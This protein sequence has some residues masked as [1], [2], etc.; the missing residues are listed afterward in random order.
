MADDQAA[1]REAAAWYAELFKDRYYLEVQ[2]HDS[3]GQATLNAR[4]FALAEGARTPGRRHQR[5]ALPQA[6][7]PRRARR[8]ALHRARQGSQ[9]RRPDALRSRALLQERAGDRRAASRIGRTCSR[10]RSD[11]RRESTSSSGRSTTCR[12]SRCRPASRREN[13]L[14]TTLATGGRE[15]A[16][17]RSAP[18]QRARAARL[19]ARRHH[20]DG[21]RR[22]LPDR[23]RLHQGGAR[24][25]HPGGT[26]PR[27]GRR[28]ARRVLAAHHQRLSAQVRSAVRALPESRARVDAR[29]RRRLLLRAARRGDRVRAAEVRHASRSARS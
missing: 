8:A 19:R 18:R 12:R 17:R 15:G 2:A 9:R 28:L 3:E 21:L 10:T 1:A 26:R 14:L 13:E 29:R 11:R 4:V 24:P 27:I 22:L 20:E 6:R 25:R 7:R 16:L 5:R 23:R